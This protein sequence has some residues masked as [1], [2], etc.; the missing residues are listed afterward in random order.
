[1]ES[2][3][4]RWEWL[5]E[6]VLRFY[7]DSHHYKI[8]CKHRNPLEVIQCEKILLDSGRS[9]FMLVWSLQGVSLLWEDDQAKESQWWVI[10]DLVDEGE[11]M[12]RALFFELLDELRTFFQQE[13]SELQTHLEGVPR[14]TV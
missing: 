14:E 13:E 9:Y 2:K 10:A 5:F 3:R 8:Y 1:M 11:K 12:H 7:Y 6:E 4:Y